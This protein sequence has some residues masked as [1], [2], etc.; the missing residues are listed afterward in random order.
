MKCIP[1]TL[2]GLEVA[3]AISL[4]EI[5]EV[6]VAKIQSG[7]QI[8]SNSENIESFKSKI[9]GTASTTK[10]ASAHALLSIAVLILERA[11]SASS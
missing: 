10:S 1:I 8:P 5:E 9:S 3:A 7:L 6:F 11:A 4:I 2:L